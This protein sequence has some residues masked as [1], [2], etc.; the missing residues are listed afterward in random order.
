ML[1]MTPHSPPF[2]HPNPFQPT[3]NPVV[4]R[5]TFF[6]LRKHM[7]PQGRIPSTT[8]HTHTHTHAYT[9][10]DIPTIAHP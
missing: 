7:A 2:G 4:F 3:P 9:N 5:T 6:F 10:A 8:T 1:P